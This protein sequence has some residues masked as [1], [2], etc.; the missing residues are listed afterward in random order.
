MVVTLKNIADELGVSPATVSLALR[1]KMAGSKNLSP[2][3]VAAVKATAQRLG[4]RPNALARSLAG[5]QSTTIGVL[6][7][8]LVFG[9]ELL[10]DGVQTSLSDDF[11]SLLSVYHRDPK[12][13]RREIGVLISNRVGGIIAAASGAPENLDIYNEIV[14]RNKIPLVLYSRHLPNLSVP[15]VYADHTACTY[16]ATKALL[17]LGHRRILYGGVSFSKW[18][19]SHYMLIEGHNRAMSE[20]GLEPLL[21]TSAGFQNW[22]KPQQRHGFAAG[23]LDRWAGEKVR[24]T[25]I[26]VDSDLLAYEILDECSA[27]DIQVPGD[28]SLMGVGDYEFSSRS[29]VGLSTVGT[30]GE[31]STQRAIGTRAAELLRELMAGKEWDGKDIVLPQ[32]VRLRKTTRRLTNT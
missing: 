2:A 9:S 30:V 29:Y 32:E 16:L 8:S 7:S 19:E 1:D 11:T 24:P 18:M 28:V 21:E 22:V 13:E 3:T 12:I 26:L 31:V 27:R 17:E 4:Y 10:L 15:T 20:A 5:Q 14:H 23:I 25:A 6:L